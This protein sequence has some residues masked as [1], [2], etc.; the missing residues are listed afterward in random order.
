MRILLVFFPQFA[1]EINKYTLS[2]IPCFGYLICK[3]F[4]QGL[5]CFRWS[6][7]HLHESFFLPISS[8]SFVP[9]KLWNKCMGYSC[10]IYTKVVKRSGKRVKTFFTISR[11]TFVKTILLKAKRDIRVIPC[12]PICVI[13]INQIIQNHL[14]TRMPVSMK[15]IKEA[16]V[17][18]GD[19]DA[20]FSNN[21]QKTMKKNRF[22]FLVFD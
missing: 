5:F 22:H 1:L 17:S 19:L 7:F 14:S 12:C 11:F 15:Y 9:V 4:S 2:S 10:P 18:K 8:K 16:L 3:I 6:I 20:S 21:H 13:S